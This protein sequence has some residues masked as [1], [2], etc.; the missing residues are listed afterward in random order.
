MP[1]QAPARRNSPP[2][3]KSSRV[4]SS[5]AGGASGRQRSASLEPGIDLEADA[6]A[7]AS[8]VD[9]LDTLVEIDVDRVQRP[10]NR[11]LARILVE[12]L[13]ETLFGGP[14]RAMFGDHSGW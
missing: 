8:A 7:S 4:A 6:L 5:P 11:R 1:Y 12:E 13:H 14:R 2:L 3:D 10:G 9:W